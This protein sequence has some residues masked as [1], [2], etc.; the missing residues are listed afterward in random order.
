MTARTEMDLSTIE[1]RLNALHMTEAERVEAI[2]AM[3]NGY[4]IVE[5]FAWLAHKITQ[6]GESLFGRPRLAR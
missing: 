2:T 4:I 6:I 1:Q 5:R 3:H